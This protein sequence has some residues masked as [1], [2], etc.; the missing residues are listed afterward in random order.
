[1]NWFENGQY[2]FLQESGPLLLAPNFTLISMPQIARVCG[3][4]IAV[5]TRNLTIEVLREARA[6]APGWS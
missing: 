4:S 2:S 3:S 6:G 1:L 5:A